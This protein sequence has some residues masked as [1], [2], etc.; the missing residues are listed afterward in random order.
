MGRLHS[1]LEETISVR[2]ITHSPGISG[3][4]VLDQLFQY[5]DHLAAEWCA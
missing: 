1:L 4:V 5:R 2:I 3:T